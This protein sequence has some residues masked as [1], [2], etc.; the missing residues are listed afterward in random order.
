M[1]QELVSFAW[2]V[3]FSSLHVIAVIIS[4][5]CLKK[6]APVLIHAASAF[7]NFILLCVVN[8]MAEVHFWIAL[9]VLAFCASFYLFMYGAI[10]KSL[11]LRMLCAAHSRGGSISV[12]ELDSVVTLPTFELRIT[13]LNEM[14][15]VAAVRD[16]YSLTSKGEKTANFFSRIRKIFRIET[17]AV[18]HSH[19]D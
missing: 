18:Y 4:L 6:V 9:T 7:I 19:L 3:A 1:N 11:T 2:G 17:K 14:G 16:G 12:D 5:K 8:E 15:N 10:Y 13:L